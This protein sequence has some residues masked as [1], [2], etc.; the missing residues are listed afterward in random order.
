M[1]ANKKHPEIPP[2]LCDLDGWADAELEVSEIDGNWFT[3][4]LSLN[5]GIITYAI[6]VQGVCWDTGDG[7]D[8]TREYLELE[9]FDFE[10]N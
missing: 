9:T 1:K 6:G 3:G 10:V 5:D 4:W 2:S 8:Y 7:Y